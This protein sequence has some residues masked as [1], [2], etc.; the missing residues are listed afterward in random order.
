MPIRF[1]AERTFDAKCFAAGGETFRATFRVLS[2]ED[3]ERTMGV[4]DE[5]EPGLPQQKDFLRAAVK[6]LAD[7]LDGDGEPVPFSIEVLE[8]ALSMADMRLG[9]L[10]GYRRGI[11]GAK[12]GN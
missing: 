11:T 7:L 6:D 12:A 1:T 10:E 5:S 9:L 4:A 8:Q 3:V 2:D